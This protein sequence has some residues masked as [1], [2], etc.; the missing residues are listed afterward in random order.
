MMKT[1]QSPLLNF[2][3]FN[4][5]LNAL[6]KLIVCDT[7]K[8]EFIE[9]V[10]KRRW[11]I[12][13]QEKKKANENNSNNPQKEM[14]DKEIQNCLLLIDRFDEWIFSFFWIWFELFKWKMQAK[15]VCTAQDV[16]SI[17]FV[18]VVPVLTLSSSD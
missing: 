7:D 3:E 1:L 4:R 11:G 16:Y 15:T 9:R 12:E 13:R 18:C 2:N 14:R 6:R 10:A 5:T 17:H 8:L